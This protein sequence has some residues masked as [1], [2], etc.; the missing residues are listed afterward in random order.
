MTDDLIDID[1]KPTEEVSVRDVFGIDSDMKVSGFAQNSARVPEFDSTY[2]FDRDTTLAI[3]AALDLE[4]RIGA[5]S[6]GHS[7]DIEELF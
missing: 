7:S 2:K 6:K 1:A 5:R 4:F 3:L